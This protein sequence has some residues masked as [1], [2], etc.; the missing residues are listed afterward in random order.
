MFATL[1]SRI[2]NNIPRVFSLL[3]KNPYSRTFGS[4]DRKYW[5][6]KIIDFPCGMQQELVLPLAYVWNTPFEGNKYHKLPRIKDYL[7][8]ILSYHSKSCHS[9]GSLDDYFPHERA[10]GATAYA[11]TALT[12]TALL[13]GLRPEGVIPSFE[14]SGEFLHSYREVGK[15]SNHM[16]IAATALMNLSMLTGKPI[17]KEWSNELVDDLSRMQHDEGWFPEY[18]GCDLG[19]QTVTVEFLARRYRKA[20]SDLL[21]NMLLKN[22]RFIREFMHPDGSFGGEYGSR[23]TY[24][25]YPGGFAIL[26]DRIPEAAEILGHFFKGLAQGT[27]NFLEDDGI[28]GH[29]LSSYVTVLMCNDI[30]TSECVVIPPPLPVIA[31]Y[32]GAGL[33]LARIGALSV[34][35]TT[36]KGGVIKVFKGN[37]LIVS[38]TGYIGELAGGVRFCQNK[39]GTS[40]G[41]V[42]KNEIAIEGRFKKYTSKR[43]GRVQMISL[44]VFSLLLGNFRKYSNFIR[45]LMQKVLIYSKDSLDIAFKRRVVLTNDGI[46]IVDEIS[47]PERLKIISLHRSTDCV[48]MHVITSDS[49]QAANLCPWEKLSFRDGQTLRFE[50]HITG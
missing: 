24:N 27:N 12:E 48:N 3:D 1:Q 13:T 21:F 38:D 41:S 35:G 10:F 44:R 47:V 18:E 31:Y 14:K 7:E 46:K 30:R 34:F 33:F 37:V 26:S 15:L 8:G 42:S 40:R 23:N 6:Y 25:F 50:R 11:L 17:W 49:F 5:H 16:A 20:P 29:I 43:L 28:F 39:S 9:D 19:Y 4:F 32:E 22:V 36:T 2:L 45:F